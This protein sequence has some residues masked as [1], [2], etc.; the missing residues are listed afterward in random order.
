MEY[1]VYTIRLA[2]YLT[3]KGFKIVRTTQDVKKPEF[4]NWLFED[5]EELQNAIAEY[6]ASR[7]KYYE[8]LKAEKI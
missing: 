3:D 8:N 7:N 4:I 1:R 5:S 6:Q 2:R